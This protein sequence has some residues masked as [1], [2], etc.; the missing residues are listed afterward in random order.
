MTNPSFLY[1]TAW[2]DE[3]TAALT[4]VAVEADAQGSATAR[5]GIRLVMAAKAVV[6]HAVRFSDQHKDR[7]VTVPVVVALADGLALSSA[8]PPQPVVFAAHPLEFT[9]SCDSC[10]K[11]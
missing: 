5:L 10:K 1:G 3:R 2:K 8:L 4:R 7:T 9:V 11:M 6:G